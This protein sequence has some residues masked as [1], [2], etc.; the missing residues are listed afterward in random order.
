MI[1][2]SSKLASL[3]ICLFFVSLLFGYNFIYSVM[4]LII[5]SA[6]V[7]Y[8]WKEAD[9]EARILGRHDVALAWFIVSLIVSSLRQGNIYSNIAVYSSFVLG[10]VLYILITRFITE[11]EELV[12]IVFSISI[13]AVFVSVS[14]IYGYY[15]VEKEPSLL[16]GLIPVRLLVVPNDVLLNSIL[17][18]LFIGLLLSSTPVMHKFLAGAIGVITIMTFVLLRS[19]SGLLA[20]AFGVTIFFVVFDVRKILWLI[21]TC[22]VGFLIIDQLEGGL[23]WNKLLLFNKFDCDPRLPLWYSSFNIWLKEPFF[24]GGL[25]HFL[26][27]YRTYLSDPTLPSCSLVDDRITP[28]PHNL[29]LETLVNQGLFGA[30]PLVWLYFS[31]VGSLLSICRHCETNAKPLAAGLLGCFAAFGVGALIELSF[32]RFWVVI[33]FIT[34]TG[35]SSALQSIVK[36]EEG[37]RKND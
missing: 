4:T 3:T 1:F 23:L 12:A 5:G 20:A 11:L 14:I 9:R 32:M 26:D 21:F 13:V 27:N 37:A 17:S 22:I 34:L 8:Y 30:F 24:G 35:L 2:T 31:C 15:F 7:L 36:S 18:P 28:W 33:V 10:F 29:M 19:R 16:V 25:T 6:L